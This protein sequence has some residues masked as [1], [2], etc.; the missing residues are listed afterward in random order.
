MAWWE[1]AEGK[2][3]IIT[4]MAKAQGYGTCELSRTGRS[5]GSPPVHQRPLRIR[6]AEPLDW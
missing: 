1:D 3:G 5:V 6:M 4:S 2:G